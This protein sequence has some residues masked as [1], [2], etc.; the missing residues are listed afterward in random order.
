MRLTIF[1]DYTL[2]VLIYLGA[3]GDNERLATIGD[4]ASAYGISENHLMKVV[5]HLA[6]Q[7]YIETTRGNGGG[8]RLARAPESI[9]IGALVRDAE[10]DLAVV[11]CFEEGNLNCPIMPA[12]TL[13]S[14]LARAMRAFF[15]VLDGQ[16]L[17]DLLRPQAKLVRIFRDV[18][19]PR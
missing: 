9:N 5:Q 15:E 18:S 6:R 7:G 3:H 1:T 10:A 8:M 14:A 13:R 17:A 19:T 2:R 16:T 11:E 12:C 4:I